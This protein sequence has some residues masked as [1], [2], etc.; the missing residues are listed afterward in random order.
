MEKYNT[1]I[2]CKKYEDSI[3]LLLPETAGYFYGDLD[4]CFWGLGMYGCQ[5]TPS[6][7]RGVTACHNHVTRSTMMSCH[8]VT[9]LAKW[10]EQVEAAVMPDHVKYYN[11]TYHAIWL[12]LEDILMQ[13]LHCMFF[14]IM[15]SCPVIHYVVYMAVFIVLMTGY[16]FHFI[17]QT[18]LN[19]QVYT[20]DLHLWMWWIYSLQLLRWKLSFPISWQW[21]KQKK[22]ITSDIRSQFLIIFFQ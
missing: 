14:C 7:R 4:T 3:Y 21:L 17:L 12:Q 1:F 11:H 15:S 2:L 8:L 16:L 22:S 9:S 5:N 18:Q 6:C 10:F 13:L 20:A 19:L